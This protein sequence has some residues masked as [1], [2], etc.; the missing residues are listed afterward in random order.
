MHKINIRK[1][2][3][4][5]IEIIIEYQLLLAK[6]SEEVI[7]DAEILKPGLRAVFED[8]AK[9]QYYVAESDGKVIA[10]LMTTYEWSDWRN[11]WVWWIQSVY[12]DK[13]WRKAGVFRQM[14]AFL[15]KIVMESPEIRGLR[16]YVD[17][18]NTRAITVYQNLGMNGDHY[19]VFEWMKD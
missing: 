14:Y 5:D 13:P 4:P 12:V 3:L 15:K 8:P 9:G 6:E 7:L 2:E 16:L 11:G 1:A 18:T 17:N 19:K 10:T